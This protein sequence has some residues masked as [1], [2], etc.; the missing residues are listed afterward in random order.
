MQ[1]DIVLERSVRRD[2]VDELLSVPGGDRVH[3]CIQC[4]T[5]GS[6]PVSYFMDNPPR[7]LLAMIRA[8]MREEVLASNTMWLCTSCYACTVQCPGRSR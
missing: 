3:D 8:G 5:C 1:S 6:C 2:F 4:G 7:K